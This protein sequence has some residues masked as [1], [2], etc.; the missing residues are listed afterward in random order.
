MVLLVTDVFVLLTQ[1]LL[2]V[3]VGLFAWYVLLRA[4]PRAFLGGLVLLLLLGVAAFTFYRGSPEQGLVGDIFRLIAIPFSPL[5]IILILLLIAF[6]ELL[7]GGKLSRTGL[8]L[9]RIAIPALLILSIPAVSY[10]LA[11]RA[12][13]EAIDIARPVAAQ[14]LPAGAR[15][16][17]VSLAQDTTRLQLRPRTQPIPAAPAPTAPQLIPPPSPIPAGTLT[18]L[19]DQPVQ[20]TERGDILTYTN[21]VYQEERARGT[22][23]L[24][25]VTAGDRP[26]RLRRT[27]ETQNEVSEAADARRFLQDLGI[28]EGDIIGD[29]NSPTIQ[30]SAVNVR[31][32]LRRRGINFGNQLILVSS[33]IEMNRAAL[34]FNREFNS[35][36]VPLTVI[37]RPTNFFTLPAREALRGRAQGR[38][39]VERNFQL[40]DLIPSIDAFSLSSKVINEY[41]TSIYYF[42]RGWIRP[43]RTTL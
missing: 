32:E 15:R 39:V 2:W 34:T 30:S 13:A 6:S 36:N 17:I 22:A 12:E 3:V 29:S 10:F 11:Q 18:L 25:I 41:V 37:P 20:L 43:V 35:N 23:P 33:A 4:L 14:A 38:D 26:E 1:V 5:G 16:V 8:I 28:P 7:R 9:L 27:G 24:V 40:A 42:L 21:Q 19:T 31:Q